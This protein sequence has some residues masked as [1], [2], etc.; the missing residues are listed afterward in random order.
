MQT[1]SA[2]TQ[3]ASIS[4]ANVAARVEPLAS[5]LRNVQRFLA[6]SRAERLGEHTV[7]PPVP[8][9]FATISR[10]RQLHWLELRQRFSTFSSDFEASLSGDE[11]ELCGFYGCSSAATPS[12]AE[13]LDGFLIVEA[14]LPLFELRCRC[15]SLQTSWLLVL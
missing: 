11:A 9:I 15:S 14:S 7:G 1:N 3:W 4:E 2:S 13:I 5:V 12:F 6:T 8:P 10:H